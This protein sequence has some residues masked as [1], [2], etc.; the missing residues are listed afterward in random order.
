VFRVYF[1]ITADGEGVRVLLRKQR[2]H[3]QEAEDQARASPQCKLRVLCH[4]VAL[5]QYHQ[6][7][8]LAAPCGPRL[9]SPCFAR[10]RAAVQPAGAGHL[11][12][13]RVLAKSTTCWRTMLMPRS[14]EAFSSNTILLIAPPYSCRATARMVDVLPVPGGP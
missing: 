11:K 5:V 1:L 9:A 2:A 10:R 6:L 12:M 13:V 7:E 14:S 4:S 8:L 3:T